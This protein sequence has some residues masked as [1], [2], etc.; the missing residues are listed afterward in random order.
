MVTA[1]LVALMLTFLALGVMFGLE[2]LRA[3]EERTY[4]RAFRVCPSCGH[5]YDNP[6]DLFDAHIAVMDADDIM[7]CPVCREHL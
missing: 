5:I 2:W 7:T 1:F 3:R 4:G 6:I